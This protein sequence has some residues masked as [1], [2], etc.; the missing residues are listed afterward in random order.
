MEGR[1]KFCAGQ[2]RGLHTNLHSLVL[3]LLLSFVLVQR[4]LRRGYV[5]GYI[6]VYASLSI[7]ILLLFFFAVLATVESVLYDIPIELGLT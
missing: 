6:Y 7:P 1:Q 4:I 3:V 2:T 5:L